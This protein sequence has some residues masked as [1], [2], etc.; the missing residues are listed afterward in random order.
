MADPREVVRAAGHRLF[1]QF[2]F[3]SL[4]LSEADVA[5]EL[6][7]AVN[8]PLVESSFR[9]IYAGALAAAC[10]YREGLDTAT[11]L[12]E[13]AARYRLDFAPGTRVDRH[14]HLTL[15]VKG[16]LPVTLRAQD[17]R[18]DAVPLT[19]DIHEMVDLPAGGAVRAAKAA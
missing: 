10:R 3:G 18:L 15:G 14:S 9:T 16:P 4:D 2:R 12:L 19:G 8:D 17:G 13:S 1:S 11:A 6:L 7:P 5:R